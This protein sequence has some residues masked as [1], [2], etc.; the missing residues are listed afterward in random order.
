MKYSDRRYR[1]RMVEEA[2]TLEAVPEPAAEIPR[3][4]VVYVGG[5]VQNPG[6]YSL[7][8]GSRVHEAVA[9]ALPAERADLDNIGMARVLEDEESLYIPSQE[10]TAAGDG[11]QQSISAAA[12]GKVNINR[13]SAQELSAALP[14]VGEVLAQNI[15]EYREKNGKFATIEDLKNVSGIG[16]KKFEALEALI[17]V[18]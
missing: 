16:E 12:A 5:A 10:E 13:A 8:E 3:E 9:L 4:I 6:I 15:V 1:E 14:G 2:L 17:T 18:R 11:G 7:P